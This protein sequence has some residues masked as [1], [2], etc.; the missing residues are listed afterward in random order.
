M[1]LEE[2]PGY[3]AA[4]NT[5]GSPIPSVALLRAVFGE[6]TRL[7]PG[8]APVV[9][10]NTDALVQLAM[11]DL[12]SNEKTAIERRFGLK[13]GNPKSFSAVGGA[14]GVSRERARQVV[15]SGLRKLRSPKRSSHLRNL[16]EQY[17]C[18]ALVVTASGEERDVPA[19]VDFA[20]ELTSAPVDLMQDFGLEAHGKIHLSRAVQGSDSYGATIAW[21]GL[22]DLAGDPLYFGPV[23]VLVV[24]TPAPGRHIELG[25][26]AIE[27]L[28]GAASTHNREEQRITAALVALRTRLERAREDEA[29]WRRKLDL[30]LQEPEEEV[31]DEFEDGALQEWGNS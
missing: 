6:M 5:D 29:P 7:L 21:I 8:L 9:R 26:H 25:R 22:P 20:A 4:T 15:A 17:A 1:L 30:I 27:T 13:D 10:S 11:T 3:D 19:L 14:I 18:T 31:T 28:E 2:I 12:P 16:T 24:L 23:P